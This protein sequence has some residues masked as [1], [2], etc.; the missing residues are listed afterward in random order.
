MQACVYTRASGEKESLL[1]FFLR[2][3]CEVSEKFI[4]DAIM[5]AILRIR[6]TGWWRDRDEMTKRSDLRFGLLGKCV[7][8]ER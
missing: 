5:V 4:E 7:A 1:L 6:I 2:R 3:R 8:G